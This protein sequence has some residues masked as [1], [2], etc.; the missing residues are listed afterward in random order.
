MTLA[1]ASPARRDQERRF[2]VHQARNDVERL[3]LFSFRYRVL[4]D[5]LGI[6]VAAADPK[7]RTLR[8]ARD[9][10]ATHLFLTNNGQVQA[11]LRLQ[12]GAGW[13]AMADK[14][15][16]YGL[17]PFTSYG[18][19]ALSFTD[20]LLVAPA[21]RTSAMPALLLGAAYKLSRGQGALFDFCHC[22]PSLVGLY[23]KLGYRRYTGNFTDRDFGLQVPM[24]MV[25]D[26][27]GHLVE[28]NSPFTRLA[29]QYKNGP[30]NAAWFRREFPQAAADTGKALRDEQQ[31]WQ[32]LTKKL[33]QNPL[34]GVPLFH[35]LGYREAVSFLR[36]VTVINCQAG[37][38][39][40]TS[41]TIGDEMFVV[42][43][44]AVEVRVRHG[45]GSSVVATYG[46]GAVLG[47][48]A[49]LAATRRTAD[50][51]VTQ[52]A[53]VLILTQTVLKKTMR[54]M[55]KIAAQVL[56]NLS[57]TLCERI[58]SSN[59]TLLQYLGG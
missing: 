29:G 4:I 53:E 27:V 7:T 24:V 6:D 33:H 37:E 58:Q 1:V 12:T 52:D 5:E 56:F 51:I 31:F 34:V 59:Q 42:L 30:E 55:P 35:G 38:Q 20:M 39:L 47:E 10:S 14:I 23:Q 43:S 36:E 28:M 21:W 46:K 32:Y 19:N 50:V 13:E 49:F 45:D 22:A 41:G 26:D 40:V 11:C 57:L 2:R 44:G 9:D 25:M 48:I 17:G 3:N 18:P 8:D 16:T 54:E 15:D